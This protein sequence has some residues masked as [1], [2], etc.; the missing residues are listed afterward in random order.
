MHKPTTPRLDSVWLELTGRCQLSC[1]HCYAESGPT[2]NH[3][4]MTVTDW[5]Q[6]I[7][8]AHTAGA[9]MVQLI[10][11]EP[12][13]HPD[14]TAVAYY[15]LGLDMDVEVATN[16]VHVTNKLWELFT[17]SQNLSLAVSYYDTNPTIHATVTG[18][19]GS[20]ARTR[21]NLVTAIEREIPVRGNVIHV[22]DQQNI[23]ATVAELEDLGLYNVGVDDVRGIG[24]GA[25][26]TDDNAMG[27]L[28]GACGNA[29]AAILPN[30][31][32]TPCVIGRRHIV[33]NVL[34]QPLT[35]II[36][37]KRM[38]ETVRAIKEATAES[39]ACG[40]DNECDPY[41]DQGH[42]CKPFGS[43]FVPPSHDRE[44]VM[45]APRPKPCNPDGLCQPSHGDCRPSR[46]CKPSK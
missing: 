16:L 41:F 5:C 46:R 23:D 19:T 4:T 40:P 14:F 11:G 17:S 9:T 43:G 21:A 28:C 42:P 26:H 38:K 8:D 24:R 27:S 2:G 1:D 30:G 33:G 31:D 25:N 12:T 10:G 6:V 29:R 7:D 3:G 39:C 35:E 37:G 22:N 34:T 20:H 18:T 32:V 36:T 15:A 44:L 45:A 13:L